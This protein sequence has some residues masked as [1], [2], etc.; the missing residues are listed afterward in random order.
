[1][2]QNLASIYGTEKDKVNCPFF[3]K[4]GACR[5]GDLCTKQHIRP[6]LS[7]TIIINQMYDNPYMKRNE[8]IMSKEEI[9][10]VKNEFNIFYED[11][12]TEIAK[13]GEIEN[14]VVCGNLNEHMNGN[15]IIKFVDEKNASE[16]MKFLLARYYAGKMIQPSYSNVTQ[17]D[18]ALCK[19]HAAGC[20]GRRSQCNF[21]HSIEPNH[22]LKRKLLERQPLRQIHTINTINPIDIIDTQSHQENEMKIEENNQNEMNVLNEMIEEND[23]IQNN[24]IEE[25]SQ[26]MEEN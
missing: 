9:Q 24:Q 3:F 13:H 15:V 12:F 4:I 19:K 21:I 25:G 5:H 14:M 7:Q 2:A 1:M 17:L 26:Q 6:D 16:A 20:C 23:I 8:S 22:A 10:Q 11:V 18:D